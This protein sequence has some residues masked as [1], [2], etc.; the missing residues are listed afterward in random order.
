MMSCGSCKQTGFFYL[1]KRISCKVSKGRNTGKNRDHQDGKEGNSAWDIHGNCASVWAERKRFSEVTKRQKKVMLFDADGVVIRSKTFGSH[2]AKTQG[3][4]LEDMLPF[5]EGIFQDCL[6]GRS[7]LKKAIAPWLN[8]WNWKEGV[9]SFLQQWFR[10]EHA[11]DQRMVDLIRELRENAISCYLATNQEKYRTD[12]MR[13]EM[14]FESMFD[15]IFSSAEVGS[16]KPQKEFYEF[17]FQKVAVGKDKI[18]YIDDSVSHV[19]GARK[20]GID[21]HLYTEFKPFYEHVKP[22]LKAAPPL[23]GTSPRFVIEFYTSLWQEVVSC[24][25]FV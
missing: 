17:I 22:M 9:D 23:I 10:Y 25:T 8:K 19:Q 6:V 1:T 2:Y 21:A 11:I 12:Y 15:G 13:K 14:G 3:L 18:L 24:A 5:Y 16:K 20:A 4:S 7:D